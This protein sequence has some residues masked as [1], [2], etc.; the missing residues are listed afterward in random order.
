MY[1]F[2]LFCTWI[3][4]MRIRYPREEIYLLDDDVTAAFRSFC[5]H[6]NLVSMHG[7]V[8]LGFLILMARLTF[9]D[10]TSPPNSEP[11]FI[12]RRELARHYFNLPDVVERAA[13]YMPELKILDPTEE[14]IDSFMQIPPDSKNPG[15]QGDPAKGLAADTPPY[16]HHVD[17]NLYGA[18]REFIL[19][20]VAA[21]ILALYAVFGEP[22]PTQPDPFSYDKFELVVS[23]QRKVTG[24]MID[25]RTMYIW[26][27]DYK[28]Q[29]I[30]DRL[31]DWLHKTRFT[32]AEGLE[33]MGVL[34]DAARYNNWGR[35]R[36]F[37]FH[38]VM[39]KFLRARYKMLLRVKKLK[40]SKVIESLEKYQL[41][42]GRLKELSRQGCN[43]VFAKY[44]YR[45]RESMPITPRL[46]SELQGLYDFL[47][48]FSNHWRINIGHLIARDYASIN[49]G[50][51]SFYG[52][53]F[54]TD[55]LRAFCMIPTCDSIRRRCRLGKD[56]PALLTM[57]VLEYVT[58]ILDYACS[59]M[60]LEDESCAATRRELFP[61][62]VPPMACVMSMK[63]NR[64]AEKWIRSGATGSIQ[65]Q[66][67]IRVMGE[68]G[69]QSTTKQCGDHIDG[70][71][72]KAAD[73]LSRPDKLNGY[74]TDAKSLLDHLDAT[75]AEYPRLA[76][77]KVFMPSRNL[78]EAI[79]W[80]LRP[81]NMVEDTDISPPSLV[82]PYGRFLSV[83]EFRVSMEFL[84]D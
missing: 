41:P 69:Q 32:M 36:F 84:Y 56:N 4:N 29:Q 51:S 43:K 73:M 53:G 38:G 35:I 81:T 72:N 3:W 47:V 54:W 50:D 30:V 65:G 27:P 68:L 62:G 37:I 42:P 48:D 31:H 40:E 45:S 10:N 2:I 67:C 58:A 80:A 18:R 24:V 75:I 34:M 20:A 60:I 64:S 23:H 57:N 28:R 61:N 12:A 11:A 76:N 44:L 22:V 15:V 7:M 77:Y 70:K 19:R 14:E 49:V 71:V 21:S 16:R 78:F 8:A 6:P 52:V 74:R 59:I 13:K 39:V 83:D 25:S 26:L 46:K 33:L 79:A 17:D 9:G 63:D 5:W 66:Q 82:A 1:T 55:Q